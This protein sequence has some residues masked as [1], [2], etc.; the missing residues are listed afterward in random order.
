MRIKNRIKDGSIE[1]ESYQKFLKLFTKIKGF[2]FPNIRK[3]ERSSKFLLEAVRNIDAMYEIWIFFE[4]LYYFTKFGDVKLELNS[5]PHF[6]QFVINHQKVKLYY[7]KTF[8]ENETIAWA[9]T[10]E[11]DFTIQ[12]DREIIGVLDAKNYQFRE[13]EKPKNKIL[14]YMT[15]L[16]TGYGGIIWPKDSMEYNFPST[17]STS[18][19]Y[20]NDLKLAFYSLNPETIMNQTNILDTMLGKIHDEIKNRLEPATKCPKCGI[21]A[22]GNSDMEKLFGFRKMDGISRVQSWCR[23]CRSL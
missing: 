3:K 13:E 7:E 10:H 5:M 14:A 16:G 17:K 11:P 12:T 19:K 21:T 6:F 22:I 15:N 23:E 1:N 2:N 18:T 20:H 4:L 8:L 9:S